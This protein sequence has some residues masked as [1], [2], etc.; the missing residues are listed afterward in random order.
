MELVKT[1][2]RIKELSQITGIPE[3]TLYE[4]AAQGRFETCKV[5]RVVLI[6]LKRFYEFLDKNTRPFYS[7]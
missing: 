1:H 2:C 6:D 4:W 7:S 5:G 3:K